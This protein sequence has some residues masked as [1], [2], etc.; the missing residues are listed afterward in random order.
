MGS[1]GVRFGAMRSRGV[2]LIVVI[3][4]S[5]LVGIIAVVV[6]AFALIAGTI[7]VLFILAIRSAPHDGEVGWDPVTLVHNRPS[8][9][10]AVI[11]VPLL[12]F[13]LGCAL[14]FRHFHRSIPAK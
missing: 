7:I 13:A 14:G 8:L 12:V 11:I 5:A 6:V 1:G 9:V 4:R 10:P 3:L 2:R